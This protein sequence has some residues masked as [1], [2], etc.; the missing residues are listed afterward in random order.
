MI[1]NLNNVI[2]A[3]VLYYTVLLIK[4]EKRIVCHTYGVFAKVRVS[5]SLSR[6]ASKSLPNLDAFT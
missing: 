4:F 1:L 3:A 5:K 2:I 6:I